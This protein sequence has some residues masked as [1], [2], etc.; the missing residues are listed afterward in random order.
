VV[1]GFISQIANNERRITTVIVSDSIAGVNAPGGSLTAARRFAMMRGE[2]A[3][4]RLPTRP[5]QR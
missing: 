5:E 2:P 3:P 4:L 1:H